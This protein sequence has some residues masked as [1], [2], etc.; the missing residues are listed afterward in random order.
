[1][2]GLMLEQVLLN[3][4][5]LGGLYAAISVGFS[6]VWGVLN[7]I[8]LVHGS[9]IVLGGYLAWLAYYRLGLHP[10]VALPAIAL[11]VGAVGA[12]LQAGLLNRVIAAPV[13]ITLVV[14]FGLDLVA[15][16]ILLLAFG[17]DYRTIR[18]SWTLGTARMLGLQLP[19]D[20]AMASICA[21][22]MTGVL[23]L[24]LRRSWLGRAIVAVRMD[25]DAA[26]LMGVRVQRIFIATFALG[27]AL[28]GAA[29]TLLALIFPISPLESQN[30][31]GTAFTVC[32]MGGLGSVL[33]AAA[34]GIAL[35]LIES[36][37]GFLLS[38]EYSG[39]V[40]FV[41]LIV[42]LAVRPEGLFG[43]RGFA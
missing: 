29:G 25:R 7:V 30:Y 43:R 6:L 10:L 34:G 18:P 4:L 20:R 40:S 38:P 8:N 16:N 15:N 26:A 9:L 3:G 14:T 17:A 42:L 2:V 31:L 13:L 28:A 11:L 19:L 22:A 5:L 37:S 21:L 24:L 23:Y 12:A 41:L 27:A 33:G 32:V 36:F 1:M 39:T 35:G